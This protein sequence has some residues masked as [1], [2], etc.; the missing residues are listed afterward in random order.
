MTHFVQQMLEDRRA[1]KAAGL[2]PCAVQLR[3]PSPSPCLAAKNDQSF[4]DLYQLP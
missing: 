4:D 1:A 2:M 3:R